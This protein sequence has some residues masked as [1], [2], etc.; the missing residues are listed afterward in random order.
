MFKLEPWIRGPFEILHHADAHYKKGSDFDRRIAMVGFDN[1]IEL[2]IT[3]YLQLNPKL[4][5]G[6]EYQKETVKKWLRNYH[7]KVEFLKSFIEKHGLA[8]ETTI[9][10]IIWYHS[11]RNEMYHSGNG[12]VPE[13]HCLDG[14][15]RAAIEVFEVLFGISLEEYLERKGYAVAEHGP[16]Y[17]DS[18]ATQLT[19]FLKS[20]TALEKTMYTMALAL[21]IEIIDLSLP[22]SFF[23]IWRTISLQTGDG[24]VAFKDIIKLAVKIRDEY[25]HNAMTYCTDQELASLT[26]DIDLLT[27][28]LQVHGFSSNILPALKNRYGDWVNPDIL[29]VRIIQ[30][31]GTP[32]LEV[33]YRSSSLS[34][35]EL[36]RMDLDFIAE[37][38]PKKFEDELMFSPMYS[39]QDNAD[40]F[41]NKLDLYSMV[42]TG[43]GDLFFTKE[44]LED[45][46]NYCRASKGHVFSRV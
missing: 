5:G 37:G 3:T 27:R 16:S 17:S 12:V 15:R 14:I 35:E 6:A 2:A 21:G 11:I 25:I 42:M 28:I 4:R 41:F 30:K 43:V 36:R 22:S 8:I 34:D 18:T 45:A 44:G 24:F 31:G 13:K 46:E 33:V 19:L 9:T 39:A 20:F 7:T 10:E 40:T 23:T 29:S 26:E 1:A 32:T 38:D